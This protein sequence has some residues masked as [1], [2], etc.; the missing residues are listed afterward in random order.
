MAQLN[1]GDFM[2][3]D[4]HFVLQDTHAELDEGWRE[5]VAAAAAAATLG[6][7][8][9]SQINQ[10]T[11]PAAT[12]QTQAA[13][14]QRPDPDQQLMAQV[15]AQ[16]RELVQQAR[17]AGIQGAELAHFVAQMAHETGNWQHMEEQPPR[18]AQNPQRYFTRKYQSKKSLGNTSPGDAYRY[19]GRGYIQLTGRYNYTRAARA[20]GLDLVKHPELAADP[21]VAARIAVWYWRNRVAPR[22]GDFDQA[23]V[24]QVTRGINPGQR[25][26]QQRQAQYQKLAQR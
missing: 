10:P 15:P 8:G 14:Q 9:Y 4:D 20:L 2:Q 18:G 17:A 25:G 21:D 13:P 1:L 22:V 12:P 5:N 24:Q 19:R 3:H 6:W 11:T 23:T 7:G 16:H 26:A